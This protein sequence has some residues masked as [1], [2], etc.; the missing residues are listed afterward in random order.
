MRCNTDGSGS[1]L[2]LTDNIRVVFSTLG[3]T[4]P[5]GGIWLG[6]G[7]GNTFTVL[8]DGIDLA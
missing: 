6:M 1:Y 2:Y 7:K 5:G 8:I 4:N 3:F